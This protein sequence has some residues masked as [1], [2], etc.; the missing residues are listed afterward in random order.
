[1]KQNGVKWPL[2]VVLALAATVHAE[3]GDRE[4]PVNLK[5]D[6]FKADQKTQVR[7]ASGNVIVT[8]GTMTLRS[9]RLTSREDAQGSQFMSG[10]GA[11]VHFRQKLD[12]GEWVD[13]E[14]LRFE[15]YGD[16]GTLKLFDKAWVKRGKDE[17]YGDVITYNTTTEIYEAQGGKSGD[18]RVNITF[19]PKTKSASQPAAAS[20]P[21]AK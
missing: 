7:V 19:Q 17:V 4:K 14:A 11:P 9:E 21:E 6:Q 16:T 10:N 13:A 3:T 2:L 18:G 20:K 15:Y 5:S 8:Q 1:M 12:S